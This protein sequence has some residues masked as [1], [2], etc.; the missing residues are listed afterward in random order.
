MICLI[1][2]LRE[3]LQGPEG[4]VN[5]TDDILVFGSIQQKHDS[6]VIAFLESCFKV[7]LKLSPT[8]IRLNCIEVPFLDNV[9]QLKEQNQIPTKL[10]Q[11]KDWPVP[12]NVKELQSV[13]G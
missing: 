10:R 8:K 9:F 4:I 7:D 13:L 2:A 11:L 1:H 6:N 3:L 5:I 12:S